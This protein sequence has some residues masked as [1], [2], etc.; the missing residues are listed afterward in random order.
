MVKAAVTT[1]GLR[2]AFKLFR[3][4]EG[5]TNPAELFGAAYRNR[6]YRPCFASSVWFY[7][8]RDGESYCW[9]SLPAF[10]F[11]FCE[12]VPR[13]EEG[14]CWKLLVAGEWHCIPT[15]SLS[16]KLVS[17]AHSSSSCRTA[18]NKDVCKGEPIQFHQ[19]GIFGVSDISSWSILE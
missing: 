9:G 6:W 1:T 10:R 2:A 18:S 12:A 15:K 4:A 17:P 7:S 5:I 8:V 13:R 3:F 19:R 11:S 14:V 16:G